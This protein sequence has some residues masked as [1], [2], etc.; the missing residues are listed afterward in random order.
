MIQ[1]QTKNLEKQLDVVKILEKK[2]EVLLKELNEEKDFVDSV[3]N[4]QEN[5]VITTDGI[6]LKTANK[7]FV[8]FY[9]STSVDKLNFKDSFVLINEDK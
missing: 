5:F 8:N 7:A 2:Q 9:N 6:H 1:T 4:S 3:I